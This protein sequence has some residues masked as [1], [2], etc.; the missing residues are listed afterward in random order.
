MSLCLDKDAEEERA[1]LSQREDDENACV[2]IVVLIQHLLSM[3]CIKDFSSVNDS[4][5]TKD[6]VFPDLI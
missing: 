6:I 2:F 3:F 5:V 4:L 1:Q